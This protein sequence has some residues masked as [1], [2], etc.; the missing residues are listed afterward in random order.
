MFSLNDVGAHVGDPHANSVKLGIYLPGITP[1]LGLVLFADL[2]HEGDQFDPQ[3]PSASIALKHQG[4]SYD[5]S[6]PFARMSVAACRPP[7]HRDAQPHL[8]ADAA[9]LLTSR[10]SR[11]STRP[12]GR[13]SDHA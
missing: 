8:F 4:T 13:P 3:V 10:E 12:H 5:F 11:P 2:I 6:K 7:P 9:S 1:A